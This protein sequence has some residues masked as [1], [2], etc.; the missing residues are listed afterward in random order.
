MDPLWLALIAI[1]CV[2]VGVLVLKLHAFLTLSFA[3]LF[4]AVCTPSTQLHRHHLMQSAHQIESADD[5]VLLLRSGRV[6]T[7]VNHVFRESERGTIDEVGQ[8]TIDQK[9]GPAAA[10]F[11]QADFSPQPGD[12]IVHAVHATTAAA[13]AKD[14]AGKRLATGFGDTC[15]KIGILI[16]MASVI[17]TCLLESGA[18]RRIVDSTRNLVGDRRTPVAFTVSGFVVGIPVFFDTVFYLLIPLARAMH[19]KTGH[20]YLLYVL[21]I[22]VGAT[23]AHSLVP[24]TP[25]PLFVAAEIG[26]DIGTMIVGGILVGSISVTVGFLCALIM[27]RIWDIPLRDNARS[28]DEQAGD[29]VPL[30]SLLV[31]LLP[32]ALP[33]ILLTGWTLLDARTK[34]L[35]SQG[36]A[37]PNWIVQLK[38]YADFV[39]DKNV[40]LILAAIVALLTLLYQHRRSG[41]SQ[42]TAKVQ[43]AVV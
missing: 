36:E 15:R 10:S 29:D 22:V 1:T 33:V 20:S 32:I 11:G 28:A 2:I 34:A 7:G 26:I 18:A 9:T 39:G 5:G 12:W 41:R 27:N 14:S 8:L 40:A 3:A 19:L 30:P 42:L 35:T 17:G 24:P 31:S 25:G 6:E 16:A 4:V 38:P 13:A 43:Q 23:M 37:I 21:S